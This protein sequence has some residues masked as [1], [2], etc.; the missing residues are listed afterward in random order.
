MCLVVFVGVLLAPI[1]AQPDT[2]RVEVVADTNLSQYPSE[3]GLNYG[4]SS[5]LRLKGI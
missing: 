2:V 1:A 3:R 4:Q 5:A